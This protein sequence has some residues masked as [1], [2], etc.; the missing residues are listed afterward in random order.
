MTDIKV[1]PYGSWQSPISSDLIVSQ[2]VRLSDIVL[3]GRDIYWV[4]MRPSEGGRNVI[5]RCTSDG[6]IADITPAD[7][8]CRTRVHEYGGRSYAVNQADVYF[9][10]FSDQRI[11]L[12]KPNSSPTTIATQTGLRF[13]DI[14]VDSFHHS[15]I[16]VCEDHRNGRT[17]PE[18]TLI[19]LDLMEAG[20][21]GD[22]RLNVLVSGSDFYA[23]PCLSPDGSQ[24]A[25]LS[26][27]HPDM[28]WDGT[29]LW[30]GKLEPD[31]ALTETE[32]VAGGRGESIFQPQW[33]PDGTLFFV[34]DRTGWWNLY[35]RRENEIKP[36]VRMEAEFGMPQ[37][38]F[39][40]STY[41]FE[42]ARRLI[43]AYTREGRWQLAGINLDDEE[44]EIIETPYSDISYLRA[45][46]GRVVFVGG[47]A[48]EPTSIVKLNTDTRMLDVLRRSIRHEIDSG[49]IS[50]PETIEFPTKQGQT[51]HAFFYSPQN[52][53]FQAPAD[54]RPPLMVISH[55][56]PTAA[57]TD[58]LNLAIQYW[59]S[60][61]IAVLDV[62][63][64]GSTGFGRAYRQRLY[65]QWGVVDTQDCVDGAIYSM[66]TFGVD[67]N[68]LVI[69][70][71][72]AGGYTTLCA[73]VF[74]DVFKAGA[75]Y[76]G[77]SD[78]QGLVLETHKFEARYLDQLIGPYPERKDLY[79]ARSPIHHADDLSCP[80]IFFQGLEDK[81]VPP[82]QAEMMVEILKDKKLPVAYV[83][84]DKEQHGFRIA[85][86]IKRA[87]DAE[88]YFYSR[89]FG[90]QL[91][92]EI[93]P[94][95]IENL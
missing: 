45:S 6:R 19:R 55:G 73:L 2:S 67:P 87:L 31:G 25:W 91:A 50:I 33:S 8:N 22:Q 80:V 84:F 26:W 81:V 53:H 60:R 76:Y 66:E 49:Y 29:E 11:Y 32:I 69:R 13:A 44:L 17:P 62:N 58:S 78:L 4:E 88:L 71:S 59:T 42:S 90:F 65:G 64:G 41:A 24:L 82:A 34:S 40:M 92:D 75:S 56:G 5:V 93:P 16:C 20:E 18:N 38:L 21:V 46:A 57:A 77:V 1:V 68:R 35:R 74:N 51:S 54:E 27:N 3:D 7:F 10:N 72:S 95:K 12:Q 63:Y 79:I 85:Q 43:C 47:S 52:K 83:V 89:I 36:V 9:S 28:P 70:G 37:W 48:T 23:S 39:G 94:V 86:N 14:I 61:G 15:L 30:I